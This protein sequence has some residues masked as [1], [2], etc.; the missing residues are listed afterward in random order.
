MIKLQTNVLTLKIRKE[1]FAK[2]WKKGVI[3]FQQS[4]CTGHLT[5]DI[6]KQSDILKIK[7]SLLLLK[8]LY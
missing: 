2:L 8:D 6:S 7:K 5:T 4:T 3:D 1:C